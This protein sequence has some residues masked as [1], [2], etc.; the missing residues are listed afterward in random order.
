MRRNHCGIQG[1]SGTEISMIVSVN[2]NTC[3]DR[4]LVVPEFVL[5]KT[6]RA[7]K[8]ALG[9][10][11]KAADASWILGE[12]GIP[13]L[14]LG[15]AAGA[16]GRQMEQMLQDRGA[17]TDFTWVEG[18]TR[19]HTIIV[20]EDGSGQSTFA[21][22]TLIVKPGHVVDLETRYSR[23]LDQ[24]S[25]VVVGGTLPPDVPFD[26]YTRL[27]KEARM[28]SIP[29]ALDASGQ[30]LRAGLSGRPTVIK[31]NRIELEELVGRSLTSLDEIYAAGKN[32]QQE[33]GCSL[34]ITLG[35]DGTLAILPD[36][37]YQIPILPVKVVSTAGAGDGMLAG[38]AA[39]LSEGRPLEDGLR[40]GTAMAAAVCM[41]LGTADCRKEDIENL[42]PQVQI[43]SFA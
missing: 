37:A 24:A 20:M 5:N 15:F 34:V 25:C 3:I 7:T 9:M 17:Q 10:G 31:P 42:L 13:S 43:L 29:V 1:V 22:P 32:I 18:E 30:S 27:V 16:S 2:P 40:L 36:A 23:A 21:V 11:G 33:Y 4:T 39:A 28:K 19:V 41:Q 38:L 12:Y 14:T 6:I 26:L 35:Q 8:F